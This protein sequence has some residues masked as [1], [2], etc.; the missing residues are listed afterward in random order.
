[1]G[2]LA[3]NHILRMIEGHDQL[4]A[5]GR[6]VLWEGAQPIEFALEAETG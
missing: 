3:G 6:K 2:Q 4:E 1:M 5:F